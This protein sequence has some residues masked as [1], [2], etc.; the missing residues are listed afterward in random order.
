MKREISLLLFA[1]FLAQGTTRT[2][3]PSGCNYSVPQTAFSALACGDTLLIFGTN[4]VGYHV[5]LTTG[6]CDS[7]HPI[8][9][10][11][12]SLGLAPAAGVRVT[13]AHGAYMGKLTIS[14]GGGDGI[15]IPAQTPAVTNIIIHAVEFTHVGTTQVDAF[16][17]LAPTASA[18]A[19]MPAG[20]LIDHCYMHGNWTNTNIRRAITAHTRGVTI[21]DSWIEEIP[22][23]SQDG[24]GIASWGGPG[25]IVATN[26]WIVGSSENVLT[27]GATMGY[28][29]AT[30][31]NSVWTHNIFYK[32][33][34]WYSTSPYYVAGICTKNP[35]EFKEMFGATIKW[36]RFEN[37][38]AGCGNQ[39]SGLWFNPITQSGTPTGSAIVTSGTTVQFTSYLGFSTVLPGMVIEIKING[40]WEPQPIASTNGVDTAVMVRP[41]SVDGTYDCSTSCTI[42]RQPNWGIS[43]IDIENNVIIN[44]PYVVGIGGQDATAAMP[45]H[46][47]VPE[48]PGGGTSHRFT[49]VNNLSW[50]DS[51]IQCASTS[52]STACLY[53]LFGVY[54]AS[55]S[56]SYVIAHNTDY[57]ADYQYF[58]FWV[59]SGNLCHLD[60]LAKHHQNLTIRDNVAQ[61]GTIWANCSAYGVGSW[62]D[63]VDTGSFLN[64]T[65]PGQT[66]NLYQP[67]TSPRV[68]SGNFVT[69]F[70]GPG[71]W[72]TNV[73]KYDYSILPGSYL[74]NA[75]TDGTDVGVDMTKLPLLTNLS[76]LVSPNRVVFSYTVPDPLSTMTANLEITNDSG[77]ATELGPYTVVNDVRPDL[78]PGNDTDL[79]PD[80]TRV[81]NVRTFP[82]NGL[83]QNTLYNF[84]LS[85]G[86]FYQAGSFTT[87]GPPPAFVGASILGSVQFR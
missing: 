75:A 20:I 79:R 50:K 41:F 10:S 42:I 9:I 62:N 8:T 81:G 18:D 7:G 24:Q 16:I 68:S 6:G 44:T 56:D 80:A 61:F 37:G 35:F 40:L 60:A 71:S 66:S 58:G 72:W 1:A 31:S 87:P 53:K 29:S 76:A 34:K 38:G 74:H 14:T 65:I 21:Q 3:C 5:N 25:P 30:S 27:G 15:I 49:F 23:D 39:I 19:Q 78:H 67:A 26:N 64:N 54:L 12:D 55:G 70:S 43:D 63:W 69:A 51:R 47:A 57:P 84:R 33:Y 4:D 73:A 2:L 11:G 83:T 48:Y 45:Q 36:N 32:P 85:I 82:V 22:Y 77:M 17:A 46:Y 13:P 59:L 52:S 28:I 86:G